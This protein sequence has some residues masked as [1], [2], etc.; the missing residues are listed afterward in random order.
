LK[1]LIVAPPAFPVSAST[2][3]SVEISIYQIAKRLALTNQVT[4]IS[5]KSKGLPAVS[6]SKNLTIIRV[7]GNKS[8]LREVINYAKNHKFDCIQ[9]DNRPRF[10]PILRR[11][12][13]KV[14]LVLVLH[15]LTFMR[16]LSNMTRQNVVRKSNAVIC[17]SEFIRHYY[18]KRFPHYAKKFHAIHL[19]ADLSRFREPTPIEKRN[20]RTRYSLLNSFIILYA[21]R[22]IPGKGVHILVKAAGLVKKTIPSIRVVL[23]GPYI[24]GYKTRLISEAKRKKIPV[25]FTGP[26]KPSN[27]HKMYW[28]GDCFI[29]PT[30]LHE[31]F[32]LVNV[33]AMASGLPVIA[34][35]RGGIVEII[36]EKN[37]ILIRD[38]KKPI[39]FAR[40][41]EKIFLM[42]TFANSL[43]EAGREAVL[44]HFDWSR[45]AADYE[46]FYKKF[47]H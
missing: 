34:S 16:F 13:P 2:G 22:I 44:V 12:F 5:R 28:L 37:G 35:K 33:E 26:V 32:G 6:K 3:G 19:G 42:P 46:E 20:M 40:E 43:A 10:I 25:L 11:H 36:N 31:A 7:A 21:G 27:M 15:S 1:I 8:Y 39:A 45:V 41:I 30:Q 9:V 14:S 24:K 29:C 38:Y 47:L 23:V 4:I 17:N 18:V